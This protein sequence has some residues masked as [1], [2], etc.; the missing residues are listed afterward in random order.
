MQLDLFAPLP[1]MPPV[2]IRVDAPKEAPEKRAET[3]NA[4]FAPDTPVTIDGQTFPLQWSKAR[5]NGDLQLSLRVE[6]GTWLL[7]VI[8]REGKTW[9]SRSWPFGEVEIGAREKSEIFTAEQSGLYAERDAATARVALLAEVGDDIT[10][11]LNELAACQR[12]LY[13]LKGGRL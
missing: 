3:V 8:R 4:P 9:R 1:A 11:A 7:V 6:P 13:V 10:P 5:E 12:R 2:S